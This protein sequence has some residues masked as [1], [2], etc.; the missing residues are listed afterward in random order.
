MVTHVDS[1]FFY[2]SSGRDLCSSSQANGVFDCGHGQGGVP[3]RLERD[4]YS[5]QNNPR[6]ASHRFLTKRMPSALGR[7]LTLL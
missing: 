3:I 2:M 4:D 6:K 1:Y 5:M 7:I